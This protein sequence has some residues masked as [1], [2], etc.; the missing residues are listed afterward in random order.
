M[1]RTFFFSLVYSNVWLA[2]SAAAQVWVSFRLLDSP[3]STTACG[4]AFLAMFW[5]YTFAKAVCF[6]E[7]A[8]ALNDPDR[9]AFLKA[10]RVPLIALGLG[11][12]LLGS[13]VSYRHGWPTLAIF[14][15]PTLAGLLYDLRLLPPGLPYRRLKDITGVKGIVVAAAWIILT[16]GLAVRYGAEQSTPVILTVGFWQ[17]LNWLINTTYFDLGDFQGD[18]EEGTLTLPVRFGY[19]QTR[20]W[21]HLLNLGGLLLFLGIWS[22]GWVP[23]ETFPACLLAANNLFLLVRARDEECDIGW[24]CDVISDGMFIFCLLYLIA[25]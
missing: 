12:L 20:R 23:R 8:D 25:R 9:T 24:E 19:H 5:V 6:D 13:V 11:G 7:K 10:Y 2:L 15:T 18:R 16:V 22:L 21:L 4:L 1:L 14:L 17:F 3:C